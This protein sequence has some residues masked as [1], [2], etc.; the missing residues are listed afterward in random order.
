MQPA[1]GYGFNSESIDAQR[2]LTVLWLDREPLNLKYVIRCFSAQFRLLTTTSFQE[3]LE[4]L[5]TSGDQ[6]ALAVLDQDIMTDPDHEQVR[7]IRESHPHIRLLVT[8]ASVCSP[9]TSSLLANKHY[10][11]CEYKVWDMGKLAAN[12]NSTMQGMM[13][14]S[15]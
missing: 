14:Q 12:L 3:A 6:I 1:R 2:D 8:S 15:T 7:Q 9:K 5:R 4:L 11:S 10:L 13:P